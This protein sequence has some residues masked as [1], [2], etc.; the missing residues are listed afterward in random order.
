MFGQR[1][2]TTATRA[3]ASRKDAPQVPM[4]EKI[5]AQLI[6]AMESGEMKWR[7]PWDQCGGRQQNLITGHRYTGSNWILTE[8]LAAYQGWS[9]FWITF[10]GARSNGLTVEKG[11]KA[12]Y[13][14]KPLPVRIEVDGPDG[15][16]PETVAFT[17][18]SATPVFNV[19][20]LTPCERLDELVASRTK[21][22]ENR[23]E[24][25][26]LAAAETLLG[27][28][29]VQPVFQGDRAFYA[30]SEDK[31]VLPTR[32]QFHSATALYS[33]W[34]HEV[35]HSTGH[36]KRL[37]RDLSGLFGTATYAKEELVAELGSV[38]LCSRMEI[39]Y[40]IE[41][42]ASYL[43]HWV[44]ILK[45]EPKFVLKALSQARRAADLV[46]PPADEA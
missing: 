35:I 18:F 20:Q 7:R 15:G 16:T 21:G 5:A 1:P 14:L 45:E 40:E 23:S 10:N 19:A 29:P 41:N 37:E 42:H 28:W 17:R 33:T 4:E 43:Q 9:H 2:M 32:K 8:L 3:K 26:R 27:Q 22:L 12:T 30:P 39:G 13:I 34:A 44:T 24:P 31:I 46:C 6:A 11:S 38:L 36:K 25:E